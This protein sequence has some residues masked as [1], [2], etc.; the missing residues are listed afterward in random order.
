MKKRFYYELEDVNMCELR[1]KVRSK[2]K[3]SGLTYE[4]INESDIFELIKFLKLELA[5]YLINGGEHAMQMSMSVAK[6]RKKDYKFSSK[7]LVYAKIE[8]DG[9]YFERREGITFSST[10]FIGLGGE[11]S[12]RNIDPILIAFMKW[13]NSLKK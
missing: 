2:F 12:D 10:G 5:R 6:L 13:T 1:E 3:S 7:G 9:S 4:S 11:F 8:I